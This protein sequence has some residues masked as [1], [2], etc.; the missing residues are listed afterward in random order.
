MQTRSAI[1]NTEAKQDPNSESS[2][3]QKRRRALIFTFS[4]ILVLAVVTYGWYQVSRNA[5]DEFLQLT[6]KIAIAFEKSD[7]ES[8]K[9][10]AAKE[11]VIGQPNSDN[12]AIVDSNKVMQKILQLSKNT[13]WSERFEDAET[14]R[15]LLPE[16][17]PYQLIFTK[18]E[19]GWL[20]TGFLS[21]SEEDV[22][23]LASEL[24]AT[25]MKEFEYQEVPE[26]PPEELEE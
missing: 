26:T 11:F 12:G 4:V 1:P 10:T 17:G 14:T 13:K 3:S 23:F 2:V 8:L 5:N 19:K 18:S 6:K 16:Q 15:Y 21:I 9:S 25:E 22:A 24:P 20:W 7:I